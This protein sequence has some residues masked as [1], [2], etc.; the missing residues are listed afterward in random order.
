M[1]DLV[2]GCDVSVY[3]GMVDWALKAKQGYQFAYAKATEGTGITD[4]QFGR[5]ALS[6]PEA[7]I[8]AG[9][10]GFLHP[11]QDALAQ[12]EFFCK[13]VGKVNELKMPPMLDWEVSD[14]MRVGYQISQAQIWLDYVEQFFGVTPI[15]YSYLAYLNGLGLPS[16]FAR[17]PLWLAAY[18]AQMPAAPAPFPFVSIWQCSDANGLDTDYFNG[19]QEQLQKFASL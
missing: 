18:T 14:N 8:L 5:N 17:Y 4:P 3:Q 13:I 6:A 16:S 9:A 19:N 10:Y 11:A 12:A 7:G 15:I 2:L 1:N